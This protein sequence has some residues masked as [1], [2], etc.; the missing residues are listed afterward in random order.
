MSN[1]RFASVVL[2]VDSTLCSVE[3]IDWLAALRG[4]SITARVVKLTDRAMR[5]AIALDEVYG[6]RLALVAPSRSDIAALA[7]VY[8]DTLAPGA[9][10]AVSRLLG[11]GVRVVIVSGG[12]RQAILPL[13]RQLGIV[14]GDVCAV[15]AYAGAD[16]A[17][18]GF[19]TGSPLTTS[20]GKLAV[21]TALHLPAPVLAVGDGATDL[22]IRPAVHTFAAFTGFVH[23]EPVAAAADLILTSFDQLVELVLA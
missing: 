13:A 2:D 22:A 7:D 17:Y 16:G 10:A 5:G 9:G 19:D 4:G 23:R 14:D 18:T 6:E 3:G 15:D 8:R 12:L 21:T 20:L 1:I 11:A